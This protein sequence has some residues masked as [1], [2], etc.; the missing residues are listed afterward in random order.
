MNFLNQNILLRNVELNLQDR[1][2]LEK[3]LNSL[4]DYL[5]ISSSLSL[6]LWRPNSSKDLHGSLRVKTLKKD[7]LSRAQAKDL[8]SLYSILEQQTLEKVNQWKKER[9]LH[10]PKEQASSYQA[11]V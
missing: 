8:N 2:F 1:H 10:P 3:N 4:S 9:F 6:S 5:P 7:F 11:I